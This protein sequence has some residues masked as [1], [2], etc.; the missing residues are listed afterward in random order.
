MARAWS[1]MSFDRDA[2]YPPGPPAL[3]S[4]QRPACAT[5]PPQSPP[6]QTGI[7]GDGGKPA[8]PPSKC[9]PRPRRYANTGGMWRRRRRDGWCPAFGERVFGRASLDF[10]RLEPPIGAEDANAFRLHGVTSG[11]DRIAESPRALVIIPGT[12]E[13]DSASGE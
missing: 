2:S 13:D 10:L 11:D 9:G 8:F 7:Q 6:R 1:R 5:L 12:L 3:S 4:V